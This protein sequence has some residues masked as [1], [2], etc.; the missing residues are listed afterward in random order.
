M[1]EFTVGTYVR[2]RE[3]TLVLFTADGTLLGAATPFTVAGEWWRDV[4]DVV[5]VGRR[6]MGVGVRVLRIL[7]DA[8]RAPHPTGCCW[9][10]SAVG[11]STTPVAKNFVPWFACWSACRWPGHLGYPNSKCRGFSSNAPPRCS[12]AS[13][14]S[15]TATGTNWIEG[16]R[17]N[18]DSLV[19]DLPGHFAALNA[20]GIPDSLVHG[21]FHPG[22]Y[23]ILDWGDCGIGNPM[24]DLRPS[25][26]PITR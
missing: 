25:S 26:S 21:D 11:I 22:R 8:E 3:V 24:L 14:Q 1:S 19:E 7:G 15:S 6:V 2:P 18:L 16:T 23:R 9:G 10:T 20:C 12:H 13:T 5:E 17:R 4:E